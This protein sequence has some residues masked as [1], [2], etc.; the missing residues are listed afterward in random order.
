MTYCSGAAAQG[1]IFVDQLGP[2][3]GA[4]SSHQ[5]SRVVRT[6][7]AFT[8]VH[9]FRPRG[10]PNSF[11]L[12]FLRFPQKKQGAEQDSVS[13]RLRERRGLRRTRVDLFRVPIATSA[14]VAV[15]GGGEGAR[16]GRGP[17]LRHRVLGA[18]ARRGRFDRRLVS[19]F[20]PRVF[21]SPPSTLLFPIRPH[22][23][24]TWSLT[25]VLHLVSS[26]ECVIDACERRVL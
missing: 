23:N 2:D 15:P 18:L 20:F 25:T 19:V 12:N 3:S 13:H 24:T 1:I 9:R 8:I 10:F 11:L 16:S 17:G 22:D 4:S 7:V 14:R 21:M 6:V 5:T 26:W